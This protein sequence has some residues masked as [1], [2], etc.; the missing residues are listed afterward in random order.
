[1]LV[2]PPFISTFTEPLTIITCSI[3]VCQC[4]GIEQPAV[5]LNRITDAPLEGSP[6][7]TARVMHAGKIGQWR[8][9]V[10]GHFAGVAHVLS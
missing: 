1:M 8:E 3:G 2:A 9:L 5:P 6:D 10:L 4:Q 7:W